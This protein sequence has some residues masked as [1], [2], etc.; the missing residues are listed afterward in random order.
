V[1]YVKLGE[2]I[3]ALATEVAIASDHRLNDHDKALLGKYAEILLTYKSSA[4][5]W[6][7]KIDGYPP[8][9][10]EMQALWTKADGMMDRATRA[11][12]GRPEA[13]GKK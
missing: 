13:D 11:Y 12:Y 8:A 1:T 7:H 10:A 2:L 3:Q 5:Q 4:E 6:K 9:E